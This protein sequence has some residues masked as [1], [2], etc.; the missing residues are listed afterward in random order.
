MPQVT[1]IYPKIR[2]L[3]TKENILISG[4]FSPHSESNNNNMKDC[5]NCTM[6]CVNIA[7]H[8]QN[9]PVCSRLYDTDKTLYILAIIS[10]FIL[11]C[12]LVK[13]LIKFSI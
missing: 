11:C 8:I 10:L 7:Y 3:E 13:R 6:S 4:G 1:P 9:C 2:R 12:L 5:S